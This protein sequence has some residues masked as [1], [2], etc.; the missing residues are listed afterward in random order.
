MQLILIVDEGDEIVAFPVNDQGE[1][2][3]EE[4]TLPAGEYPA[5]SLY[6]GTYDEGDEVDVGVVFG[7]HYTIDGQ[8]YAIPIADTADAEEPAEGN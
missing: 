3:G 4:I 8:T 2:C 7:I 5:E 1:P 6:T